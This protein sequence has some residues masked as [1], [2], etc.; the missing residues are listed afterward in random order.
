MRHGERKRSGGGQ[1]GGFL[2]VLTTLEQM[3]A[4]KAG[5]QVRR[6]VTDRQTDRLPHLPGPQTAGEQTGA[7]RFADLPSAAGGAKAG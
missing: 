1:G 7:G 4:R 2:K 5:G 3:G 6:P